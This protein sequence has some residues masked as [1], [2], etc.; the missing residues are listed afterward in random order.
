MK[1]LLILLSLAA[2]SLYAVD[3]PTPYDLIRPT[4]PATWDTTIFSTYIPNP[5]KKNPVPT[6]K[7]PAAFSPGA[8][9]PD[10]LNQAYLDAMNMRISKI[11][12]NQAGYL[13]EDAVRPFYYIGSATTFSVV[14]L[15][16]KELATGTLT[17]TG[18]TT[19]SNWTIIAGTDAA[20]NDQ[21]RYTVSTTGPS[22]TVMVGDL[23]QSLPTD[24][25]LR[26]KVGTEVSADFII[27]DK[28]Y[29]MVRDAT[30]K[31]MGI[32]RSGNS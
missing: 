29:S 14:D 22:G 10:T 18:Q 28:V 8:Y 2:A 32:A 11:R 17:S 3:A 19:A 16:G 26:V 30:L 12:V 23:P 25:R 21:K 4:W 20:T 1:R 13:T 31:F 5:T 9:I 24:Q 15:T 6:N 7:T 27:S